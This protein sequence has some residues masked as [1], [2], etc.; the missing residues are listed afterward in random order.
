MTYAF[1][2]QNKLL[3]PNI[4]FP[5]IDMGEIARQFAEEN[6]MTYKDVS[7][8]LRHA[9]NA[10]CE[11]T[12]ECCRIVSKCSM[13]NP[14]TLYALLLGEA[15]IEAMAKHMPYLQVMEKM[16]RMDATFEGWPGDMELKDTLQAVF[17]RDKQTV[18]V[19]SSIK[20]EGDVRNTLRP[21]EE[22]FVC[23]EPLALQPSRT[24][25]KCAHTLCMSCCR[26]GLEICP[27]CSAKRDHRVLILPPSFT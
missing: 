6:G 19:Y 23:L 21:D 25:F 9:H 26:A 1:V 18:W 12:M 27:V 10:S 17:F 13:K 7:P 5:S 16:I 14:R 3:P 15:N 8:L 22:C 20:K 4:F 2:D 24:M 11:K